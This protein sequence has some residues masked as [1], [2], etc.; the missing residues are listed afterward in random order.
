MANKIWTYDE[1]LLAFE[2]YCRIP[3]G[4]INSTHPEII[5]LALLLNRTPAAVSMKMC[6]L[7]RLDPEEIAR[8]IKGLS[9]GAKLERVIWDNF[10]SDNEALIQKACALKEKLLEQSGLPSELVFDDIPVGTTRET[11]I[12]QRVGQSFFRATVL[13]SYD[14]KCCLT[15]ISV[16][17]FLTASHI[18]PW[19]DS[20]G[21]EKTNP[22]NGLCLN[23]LHDRAFDK[24]FITLDNDYRIV[25]SDKLK[26]AKNLD[27][28]TR[29]F[30]VDTEHKQIMLPAKFKPSKEF[31][32]FHND[33]VFLR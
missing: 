14:F 13:A 31:I 12:E 30:I 21:K 4:K 23:A 7:A 10:N 29:D 6:N 22:R 9:N 11:I 28:V 15:G 8:G 26:K 27:Q 19:K 25:V 20:D 2:L 5:K 3:F 17:A 33:V 32:Q 18:K 16:P 24:G 1:S